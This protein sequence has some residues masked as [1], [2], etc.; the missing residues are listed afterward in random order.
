MSSFL[1]EPCVC[2]DDSCDFA[3]APYEFDASVVATGV[4]RD[5]TLTQLKALAEKYIKE[6][7]HVN[8]LNYYKQMNNITCLEKVNVWILQSHT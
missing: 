3:G 8:L 4:D 2:K 6:P 1:Y 7:N 5:A